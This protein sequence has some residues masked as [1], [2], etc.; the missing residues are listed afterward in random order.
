MTSA[1]SP[2][3][4]WFVLAACAGCEAEGCGEGE[5]VDLS[6]AIGGGCLVLREGG[7]CCWGSNA[8]GELGLGAAERGFEG[9]TRVPSLA[10]VRAVASAY[11]S[12]C[13]LLADGTVR[14]WGLNDVGQ[15]GDASLT[16]RHAPTAVAGLRDVTQ[17]ATDGR[18]GFCALLRDG[19]P[20]CWGRLTWTLGDPSAIDIRPRPVW[21]VDGVVELSGTADLVVRTVDGRVA[22]QEFLFDVGLRGVV[23][24]ATGAAS[25][26]CAILADRTLRCWGSNFYGEL[27]DGTHGI[28]PAPPTDPGLTGVQSVATGAGHTCAILAD[29]TVRCWGHDGSG[30]VGDGDGP[31]ERCES[32]RGLIDPCRPRP[33]AVVGLTDVRRLALGYQSS[34]AIRGDGSLW[35]W[36]SGLG[37]PEQSFDV[38]TTPVEVHWR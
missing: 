38:H 24:L 27:G 18:Q 30:E 23:A 11:Q 4:W 17:L 28:Q 29:R 36:G 3:W 12:R 26:G 7:V 10:N 5:L 33:V 13:A 37:S 1:C 14:C 25:H 19:S 35:C 34:C 32:L 16:D 31:T 21:G 6:M 22:E 15:I 9:P 20:R 8:N 2:A